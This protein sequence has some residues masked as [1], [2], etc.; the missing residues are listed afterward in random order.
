MGDNDCEAQGDVP[1]KEGKGD[2]V[3]GD[4]YA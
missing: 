4:D 3:H 2:E 1:A